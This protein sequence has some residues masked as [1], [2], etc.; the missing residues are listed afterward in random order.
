MPIQETTTDDVIVITPSYEPD[1]RLC[2]AL[3]RS[4]E[5]YFPTARH[6]I[7]VDRR[8]RVHFRHL[9]HGRTEVVVKQ[10]MLPRS[11][12]PV[13]RTNRWLSPWTRRPLRG[14]LI[15]QIVKFAAAAHFDARTL[16]LIDSDTFLISPVSGPDLSKNGKLRFY[17]QDGGITSTMLD[18]IRWYRNAHRLLGL[19][20]PGPPP[21][22]DYIS[23]FVAWDRPTVT[24]LLA[25]LEEVNGMSWTRTIVTNPQ[26]SEF[27]LYGVFV[28]QV[29][30]APSVFA[31]N[32][33]RCLTYWDFA[34]LTADRALWLAGEAQPT[35]LAALVSSHSHTDE[36]I[37]NLL[38][39]Y[40]TDGQLS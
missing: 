14:W 3:C 26:L 25:R 32:D 31:T 30:K 29:V 22:P 20:D 11:L 24:Q 17:R 5:L 33:D 40:L 7:V 15:Q 23:S 16:L 2:E 19:A 9:E 39:G 34:P 8:D 28:D 27:L 38:R 12:V 18:H 1:L 36:Q 21:Y 37:L 4:V 13:P 35:D 6:V 10:D